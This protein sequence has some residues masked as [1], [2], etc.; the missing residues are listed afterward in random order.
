MRDREPTVALSAG[1]FQVTSRVSVTAPGI[2]P[3]LRAHLISCT[4]SPQ[5]KKCWRR[6]LSTGSRFPGPLP[7]I[8][9]HTAAGCV[10]SNA[11]PSPLACIALLMLGKAEGEPGAQY[12][13]NGLLQ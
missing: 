11:V 1:M 2:E 9:S 7:E 5:S 3:K 8:Y 6:N 4:V 13:V 10:F 12:D